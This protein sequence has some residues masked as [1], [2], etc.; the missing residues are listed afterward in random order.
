MMTLAES[1]DNL[2]RQ[3]VVLSQAI[4]FEPDDSATNDSS[5]P[6][7]KRDA[8]EAIRQIYKL[9]GKTAP[10]IVWCKSIYQ[11]ATLPSLLIGLMH[12][13]IWIVIE[14]AFSGRPTTKEWRSEYESA[15]AHLWSNG[16]F[17]L[18]RGMKDTSRIASDYF[19]QETYLIQQLKS[20]IARLL[21][22]NEFAAFHESL[23]KE[24]IYRRYWG[25]QWQRSFLMD[26]IA[27]L[28]N[29]LA[30]RL[31]EQVEEHERESF[32]F[33][34]HYERITAMCASGL[35]SLRSLSNSMGA[36]PHGQLSLVA[37]LPLLIPNILLSDIW[38][39][40]LPNKVFLD[41]DDEL[42]LMSTLAQ[43]T[44]GLLALEH[45]AFVCEKPTVF[46]QDE[47]GRLHSD[48]DA[49]LQFSD[50]MKTYFWH[51]VL[52]DERLILDP[53]SI[54]VEEIENTRNLELRRVLVE[55]YGAS[56]YLL[57]SGAEKIH[58]DD[59]GILYRREQ[60][61]DEPLVMVKVINSTAEPDGTFREYFLRV[62]PDTQT[63]KQGVA[64][65]FGLTEDE[66]CPSVES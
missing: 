60:A 55:R 20:E 10:A 38:R 26:R 65:T 6:A 31:F 48:S 17:K 3:K 12:S 9:N 42:N 50:G 19:E 4:S 46:A 2:A 24:T 56:R 21:P 18:L 25:L 51:G 40:K 64:W 49:A 13:P 52:V 23:P 43:S 58:Q 54:T 8:E 47:G 66:Y 22:L 14:S 16:G 39:Q 35:A 30:V 1:F 63:A 37:W 62:P 28:E 27:V 44:A 11:L 45:L 41:F 32:Q 57:D 15:W 59:C 61:G 53:E 7:T 36:E 29:T 34:P 5:F 33:A